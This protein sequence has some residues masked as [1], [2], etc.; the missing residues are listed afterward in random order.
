MR[1]EATGVK[2]EPAGAGEFLSTERLKA[3]LGRRTARGGA[4]TVTSQGFKFLVG[5]AGTVVLARLLTPED[6]GLVG[7]V[8]IVTG[9]VLLFKDLGLASATIQ[10]EDLSLEQVSTLF[11]INVGLSVL[12][13]LVTAA[14]APL[15]ARFYGEPRLTA[16]TVAYAVGF[17]F[18]G[19]SVQHEALLRRQM[20]FAALAAAEIASIVAGLAV[21]VALAWRGAGYWALVVN[22]LVIG[23]VYAACVWAACGWRPGRPRRG[24]GVRPMLAFG[25]NLTGFTVVNYFARNLDNMLIGRY[26]GSVQLGLYAKAYQL[27][28]LPIDQI[29]TPITSVAVPAL[30]RL[31]GEP[32]RYR[33]AYRRLLEKVAILTM[34]LMALLVATSDWVVAIVLGPKWEG[35]GRIFAVLGCV[36]LVQP[37]A[38]TTGWL[39]VS[40]GRARQMFQ[41]GMIGGTVTVAGIV[42]GLPWGAFGVAVSYSAVSLCVVI[43]ALF[44][45][46]GREGPV[47]TGDFYRIIAAPLCAALAALAALL[48]FRRWAQIES[49]L[50]GMLAA[51]AIAGA[52]TLL[53]MSA[54]PSGRRVLQDLR[55][56]ASTL[57]GR[58]GA[59]GR[60]LK[61]GGAPQLT[62]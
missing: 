28:L 11:W 24:A 5:M 3:D 2:R 37:I 54:L 57:A 29:N 25:G 53:V 42:A 46:V 38:N 35:V 52:V 47:R 4:V 60:E 15:V 58:G 40:Q 31:T 56:L 10:K 13:M 55:H 45:F 34:P 18:G 20:R 48:A 44:W 1:D 36:G 16:I 19:L 50:A 62:L 51:S 17:L 9:F 23:V 6:Y 33:Q 30:S 41:W 14:A 49:P 22:Q 8:V 21:A 61:G 26:W 59:E 39:F 27:L 43:P 32:E 7:M 12:I